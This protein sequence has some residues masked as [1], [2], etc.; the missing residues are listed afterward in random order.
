MNREVLCRPFPR[1]A[2]RTRPG[3]HG[4]TL[5]YV[6]IAAVIT[7]LN[8]GCDAWSFEVVS[9][10]VEADE[11]HV[12]G[13]LIADG[14]TKMHFGGSAI[15]ADKD[16]RAV[17]IADDLKAAASDALKK[18]AS[19][20]G[21]ALELYGGVPAPDGTPRPREVAPEPD[22][23]VT[24]R[25]LAAI[26]AMCRKR[27]IDREKLHALVTQKTGKSGVQFLTRAEASSVIDELGL[28]HGAAAH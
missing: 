12:L 22:D 9:Y 27:S 14:Q 8:E 2:I 13:K 26:Q 10:K 15:T 23:R 5:S 17:S 18:C 24:S 1:E 19:L 11:V 28:T 3:Q 7:R 6:D 16:G 20:F 25:Q 21:V 4:K